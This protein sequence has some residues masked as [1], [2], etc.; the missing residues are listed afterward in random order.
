MKVTKSGELDQVKQTE[1]SAAKVSVALAAYNGERYL[2]SQ[3]TSILSQLGEADEVVV[4]DDASTD[5]TAQLVEGLKDARIRLLRNSSNQGVFKSFERAM[6]STSGELVFLSDQDDVWHP[7]K[8]RTVT[9]AFTDPSVSLVLSDA[10]VIDAEGRVLDSSFYRSTGT[11]EPGLFRTLIRNRY[12]GCTMAI[13]R[14]MMQR[15]LPFPDKMPMHDMWIGIVNR[16]HGKVVYLDQPLMSYRRHGSNVSR[17]GSV[18]QRLKWRINLAQNL[19][20]ALLR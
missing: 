1:P 12:L 14:G 2:L 15:V 5:S 16:L 6:R 19:F 10:T 8:V 17:S 11:F 7:D 9:A 3:L 4:V 18:L 13:R 20:Q